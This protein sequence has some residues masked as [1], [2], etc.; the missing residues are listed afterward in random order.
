[1]SEPTDG[2]TKEQAI[3]LAESGFW[4]PMSYLERATFQLLE[5]RLCMPFGVFHEAME[6][7]LG[8]PVFTHEFGLNYNGL[9]REL[10]EGKPAP[11]FAE[12]LDMIPADKRIVLTLET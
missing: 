2:L 6:K 10:L 8:R 4:E 7:A 11:T 9:V 12:I 5:R 1:M 3:A